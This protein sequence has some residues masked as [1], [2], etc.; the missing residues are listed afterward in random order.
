MRRSVWM[1]GL[2]GAWLSLATPAARADLVVLPAAES[3]PA[4]KMHWLPKDGERRPVVV[5]LHGCG[6]LY[7]ADGKTLASR[8]PE[9]TQRLHGLGVHVLM[10]DSF[11]SRGEGSICSQK[12]ETRRIRVQDRRG[13]VL[14]ALAWLRSQPQVDADRIALLGWSNGG[15]TV[16]AVLD[17]EQSPTPGPLAAAVMF[18]PG[19]GQYSHISARP[20]PALMELGADD[21]WTPAAPCQR[22]AERWRSSGQDVTLHLHPG[23]YHDFDAT[24]PVRFRTDVPNGVKKNGV[25]QGGN[26]AAREAALQ[27]LDSFLRQR[28]QLD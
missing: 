1:A 8:Y 28:L 12:N 14:A 21:D 3:R 27:S 18:Y 24:R 26:P 17:A 13:D 11:G 15:S 5:A 7:L 9:Y 19:C 20:V 2:L 22:L 23:A 6:G 25:H 16:L 4:L 10:P